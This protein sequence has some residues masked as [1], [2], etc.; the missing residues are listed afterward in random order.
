MRVI[1]TISWI[2]TFVAIGA[3]AAAWFTPRADV[4]ADTAGDIAV[5][6]LEAADIDDAT[7]IGTPT[8]GR[9]VASSADTPDSSATTS[10]TSATPDDAASQTTTTAATTTEVRDADESVP[11]WVVSVAVNDAV[12]EMRVHETEGQLV[13]VDDL[14]GE[15]RD[16][17]LLT[18]DEWETVRTYRDDQIDQ[19]IERNIAGSVAAGLIVAVGFV[20]A[21]RTAHLGLR[22]RR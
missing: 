14:I 9:H 3:A 22:R 11:V 18:D 17:R 2:L 7:V 8:R 12:I 4:D 20:L 19:W 5:R 10:T 16:E 21:R 1:R 13:Y 15:D 6:A